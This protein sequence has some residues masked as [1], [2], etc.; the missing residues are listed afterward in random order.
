MQIWIK[1]GAIVAVFIVALIAFSL[2][3]NKGTTDMTSD[4][5]EA[6]LPIVYIDSDGILINEMHGYTNRMNMATLRQS[7]VPI[8]ESRSLNIHVEKYD[9]QI[10]GMSMELRNVEGSRLIQEE[11]VYTY[12][13]GPNSMSASITIKDLIEQNKEYNLVFILNLRDGRTVYYYT[14]ITQINDNYLQDKIN[15]AIDFSEKTLDKETAKEL[16][17]YLEPNSEGDNSTFGL[18]TIHS[19]ANQVSWGSLKPYRETVRQVTIYDISSS[20]AS[21][22]MRY[23]L[24]AVI[25]G[26]VCHYNIKEFIRIRRSSERFYLLSYDR[27]MDQIF[28]MDKETIDK[29]SINL[30]I[31]NQLIQMKQSENGEVMGFVTD[32]RLYSVNLTENKIARIFAF[33]DDYRDDYRHRYRDNDIKILSVEETGD[34]TFAVY[35]YMNRGIHEGEC[36]VALYS[37]SGIYNTVEEQIFIP[38]DLSPEIID[39]DLSKLLYLSA[40][41]KLY[42]YLNNRILEV[43][44]ADKK[45]NT[46]AEDFGQSTLIASDDGIRIAWQK[47]EETEVSSRLHT[48]NLSTG[49]Q[50]E[51]IAPPDQIIVGLGF[52]DE[53]IIYGLAAQ[54]DKKVSILG[55]KT[56]PMSKINIVS[57]RGVVLKEYQRDDIYV[58]GAKVEDN[59]ITLHRATINDNGKLIATTDDHITSNVES[60]SEKNALTIVNLE[61][62]KRTYTI[63]LKNSV[64]SKSIK[65]LTPKEVI[66]EGNRD[67]EVKLKEDQR[68]I[69][70]GNGAI[71]LVTDN[72][73]E[74]VGLAWRQRGIVTDTY[75]N[76]IY[77][78][79]ETVGRNQIMAIT[80]EKATEE[81]GALAV[82]LD[83]M[84]KL[85]NVSRLTQLS[86]DR[87]DT[88][89][90][91][92]E[93]NLK[94]M[95]ILNL[96]GCGMDLIYYYVNQDI[97]VL[98]ILENEK[99]VLI[100]GYNTQNL[101][102]FDPEQGKIYKYGANDSRA[103]LAAGGNRFLTYINKKV[104]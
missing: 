92:L 91:I 23:Q 12:E 87:G 44:V 6:S 36:G 11:K 50:D 38:L 76:E 52:I 81:Q 46:I 41:G 101:V 15:F 75:G 55:N 48:M 82:C 100:V 1:R 84:L 14:R 56:F 42:M 45:V 95:Y 9:Q 29:D 74:A 49:D 53:D 97:P 43:V 5:Q 51:L 72:E 24:G 21:I 4:R 33:Y 67:V 71:Q 37:Y 90:D 10:D 34:I 70:Y 64:D 66:Y 2:F 7:I 79:G 58:T 86:I 57:E 89:S 28:L 26:K 61:T 88:V 94:N 47:R 73:A 13:D 3:Y 27:T 78:R 32:G 103:L 83:S 104:D 35:G 96:T 17:T 93:S 54:E 99:P 40:D 98:A 62:Q 8:D 68:F 69:V 77:K 85:Q 60:K 65:L 31:Q 16:S 22:E 39:H 20:L 63:K 19:S 80:E 30:G 59:Q 18:V 102:L 25:A